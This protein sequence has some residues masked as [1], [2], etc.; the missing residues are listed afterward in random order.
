MKTPRTRV[1]GF[2]HRT[3][4]DAGV[5]PYFAHTSL[6]GECGPSFRSHFS[7][8]IPTQLPNRLGRSQSTPRVQRVRSRSS[9][10]KRAA[11]KRTLTP[12]LWIQRLHVSPERDVRG[13][14]VPTLRTR[15][16]PSPARGQVHTSN[17]RRRGARLFPER[18][19]FCRPLPRVYG[20]L[21]D[22]HHRRRA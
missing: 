8:L 21:S 20:R 2:S 14:I 15:H 10:R 19:V 3:R 7:F 18:A 4:E 5:R 9:R 22:A 17:D 12:F 1:R 6:V 16:G 13:R 11:Q